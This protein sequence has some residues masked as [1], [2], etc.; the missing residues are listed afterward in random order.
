MALAQH[1]NRYVDGRAPW[2]QVK[3]DRTAAATTLWTALNIVETL[4][5][6]S[7]PY[8]PHSAQKLHGLLGH[9][10]DVLSSGWQRHEPEPGT[11]LPSPTPMFKKLDDSIVEEEAERLSAVS[12]R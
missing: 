12:A 2:A 7:Y 9:D 6:V 3:E 4:R 11:N 5:T 1:G 10:G 8:L